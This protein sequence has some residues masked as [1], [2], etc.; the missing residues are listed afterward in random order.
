MYLDNKKYN[1]KSI[2]MFNFFVN[3]I[4][5]KGCEDV[6]QGVCLNGIGLSKII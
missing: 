1:V 6:N 4:L 5:R 3:N 2:G